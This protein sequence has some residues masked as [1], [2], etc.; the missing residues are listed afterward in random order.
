M[1]EKLRAVREQLLRIHTVLLADQRAEY[2]QVHGKVKSPGEMLN[3]LMTHEAFSWLRAVSSL[4]VEM[5]EL[6]A[7]KDEWNDAPAKTLLDYTEA[8]MVPA[9]EGAVFRQKYHE[10][11]HRNAE[12]LVAHGQLK[13]LL[14]DV[15]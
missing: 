10:V 3:L 5:D 13:K 1:K 8:L 7:S 15:L 6:L 11:V 2:E 12:A 9:P 4:I 14:S